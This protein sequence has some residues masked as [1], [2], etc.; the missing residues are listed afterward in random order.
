MEQTYKESDQKKKK[1]RMNR[2][3]RVPPATQENKR[4][5]IGHGYRKGE[6]RSWN[7]TCKRLQAVSEDPSYVFF[8]GQRISG[9]VVVSGG[10]ETP[11][12]KGGAVRHGAKMGKKKEEKKK[13][14]MG[15]GERR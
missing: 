9:S 4:K 15:S 1:N 13:I 8:A 10:Q 12:D 2:G 6:K 14:R 7:R 5:R 11:E 3:T